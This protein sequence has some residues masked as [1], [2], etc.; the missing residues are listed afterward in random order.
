MEEKEIKMYAIILY[1]ILVSNFICNIILKLE[2]AKEL[3]K[4]KTR[5]A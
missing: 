5:V 1:V 2:K 3:I 4:S